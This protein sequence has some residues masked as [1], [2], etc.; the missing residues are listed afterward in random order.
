MCACV[1]IHVQPPW[2]IVDNF[3]FNFH[4]DHY[5]SMVRKNS[6]STTTTMGVNNDDDDENHKRCVDV[7]FFFPDNH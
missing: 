2:V 3:H 4:F 5:Y 1:S 6:R 7:K